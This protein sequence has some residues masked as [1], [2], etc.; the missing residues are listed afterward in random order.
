M[1]PQTDRD[2]EGR[3]AQGAPPRRD[4]PYPLPMT[5]D[6]TLDQLGRAPYVSLTTFR[7]DGTGVATPVWAVRED[8]TLYVWTRSD[9]W[10]IKR[11]R[12]DPRVRVTV[13]DVRGK[14][15]EDAPRAE[16]TAR[17]VEDAE[18]LKRLRKRFGRKYRLQFHLL[19]I[20]GLIGRLGKRPHTGIAI[21]F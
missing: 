12:R 19:D 2:P 7:K 18:G 21:T 16:G 13:C 1:A 8:D 6:T 4:A 3:A 20:G 15:A 11:L 5:P 10:K 14:V 17:L 9:S